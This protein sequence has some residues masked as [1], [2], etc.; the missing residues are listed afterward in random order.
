MRAGIQH[1]EKRLLA[2]QALVLEI[3]DAVGVPVWEA[4][5]ETFSVSLEGALD[6]VEHRIAKVARKL[7]PID[8]SI[9]RYLSQRQAYDNVFK[10]R[11]DA[12]AEGVQAA[13]GRLD[14]VELTPL[15]DIADTVTRVIGTYV[16]GT[17]NRSERLDRR[18]PRPARKR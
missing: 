14:L 3:A 2:L 5:S 1:L 9:N 12:I 16:P 4:P 18:A 17:R 7:I 15:P 13:E 8:G 11:A 10:R 6:D